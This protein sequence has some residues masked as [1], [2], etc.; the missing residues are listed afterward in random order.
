[1]LN[2]FILKI[3]FKIAFVLLFAFYDQLI[4][5]TVENSV[6]IV[7]CH[8]FQ[9]DQNQC[10]TDIT[11]TISLQSD[12]YSSV[13]AIYASCKS[14]ND[15]I[16]IFYN[17][18]NTYLGLEYIT[19]DLKFKETYDFLV[20]SLDF[21]KLGIWLTET[22]YLQVNNKL[23]YIYN[24][25]D[26]GNPDKYCSNQSIDGNS[27]KYSFSTLIVPTTISD[28]S[29]SI[30]SSSN[31]PEGKWSISNLLFSLFKCKKE[32]FYNKTTNNCDACPQFCEICLNSN[33]CSKC[34]DTY[35]LFNQT[36]CS[37]SC[38]TQYFR[39]QGQC[40]Q[41][42][43]KCSSCISST[44][45]QSCSDNTFLKHCQDISIENCTCN[46]LSQV[47]KCLQNNP[48]CQTFKDQNNED[49]DSL[50]T[51]QQ[52][53]QSYF[54]QDQ[55]CVPKCKQTYYQFNDT[56]CLP[57]C[58][59]NYFSDQ[60][61]NCQSCDNSCQTCAT[62]ADLCQSC[63][64]QYFPVYLQTNQM[65][66]VNQTSSDIDIYNKCNAKNYK[67]LFKDLQNKYYCQN[68]CPYFVDSTI[69]CKACDDPNCSD[70]QSNYQTCQTCKIGY[71][72]IADTKKC[73]ITCTEDQNKDCFCSDGYYINNDKCLKCTDK[74]SS[75]SQDGCIKCNSGQ[76][77]DISQKICQPCPLN[78]ISCID[79]VQCQVCS[80]SYYINDQKKC[81]LQ[82]NC[83]GYIQDKMCKQCNDSCQKCTSDT[84]C[85]SCKDGFYFYKGVN[86]QTCQKSCPNY[87][88][89]INKQ[90]VDSCNQGYIDQK[91]CKICADPNCY[92]CQV[93]D[94]QQ[95][96]QKCVAKFYLNK[97]NNECVL[98]CPEKTFADKA[99]KTC[100]PCS[101]SC[102]TCI[103]Q[104]DCQTC[105]Q[106]TFLINLN[107][108]ILCST[109]NSGLYYYQQ[110]CVST[111]PIGIGGFNNQNQRI[112]VSCQ[113]TNC[114]QCSTITPNNSNQQG[115]NS[116]QC[117][118]C[119]SGSYLLSGI[120]VINCPNSMYND[121]TYNICQFCSSQCQTCSSQSKCTSCLNGQFLYQDT[122]LQSCPDSFY[123]DNNKCIACP[124]IGCLTCDKDKCYTCKPY[125]AYI[126]SESSCV[127]CPSQ[128]YVLDKNC[129]QC[130]KSS[131]LHVDKQVCVTSDECNDE[132]YIEGN[133]CKKCL[134]Q[135]QCETETSQSQIS[136]CRSQ[137]QKLC[138][139][140]VDGQYLSER[141]FCNPCPQ[142]CKLCT[143][144]SCT[145]CN[146]RYCLVN[147]K[148]Y[149]ISQS[150]G[151][152]TVTK[153]DDFNKNCINSGPNYGVCLKCIKGP[154]LCSMCDQNSYLYNSQCVF[155]CPSELVADKNIYLE[156]FIY[157]GICRN[158]CLDGYIKGP[159]EK[160][161]YCPDYCSDCSPL[162]KDLAKQVGQ[163][164]NC[165][166][167][168]ND[169][170]NN[171]Y[172][173]FLLNDTQVQSCVQ[174]C[175][176]GYYIKDQSKCIQCGS[177]CQRCDDEKTCK[178]CQLGYFLDTD[179]NCRES[180][181]NGYFQDISQNKC[182]SCQVTQC[183]K[184]SQIGYCL[185]CDDKYLL[186]GKCLDCGN[187][188]YAEQKSKTCQRCLFNCQQCSDAKSCTKCQQG[189]YYQQYLQ[190][191]SF[192]CQKNCLQGYY[193]EDSDQTCRACDISNCFQCSK[194]N[195]CDQCQEAYFLN[196]VLD[197]NN[198]QL[199]SCVGQCNSGYYENSQTKKCTQCQPNCQNC[200]N[201]ICNLCVN[202]F[203]LTSDTQ[204]C[205]NP[206]PQGYLQVANQCVKCADNCKNCSVLNQCSI[207][208]DGFYLKGQTCSSCIQYCDQCQD[209][210]SCKQCKNSY[211]YNQDT[212]SCGSDCPTGYFKSLNI[213]KKCVSNCLICNDENKCQTC[214]NQFYLT[215]DTQ[216]CLG[217]CP[218]GYSQVQNQ[219]I[220]C[221]QNCQNCSV[222]DQ[223][224]KCQDGFYL[225]DQQCVDSCPQG[226]SQVDTQCVKCADNC[227]NCSVLNQC[228]ICQDGFYLKGQ[229]CSQCI[230]YCDQC[231]DE[232]TCKQCS[233]SYYYNQDTK[234]C[235]SDCPTG[236]F[237]SQNICKKCVSNCLICNDENKCQ[238]CNDQFYL[239]S[240]TQQ[241][242]GQC[243]QGYSQVQNQCI[244]CAQNCQNCSDPNQCSNCQI[245]YYLSNK[246]CSPCNANCMSCIDENKCQ[247][248]KLNYLYISDL[249]SCQDNC[250][251]GYSP[252]GNSCIKCAD[253]CLKCT[254][255]NECTQCQSSFYLDSQECSP[256]ISN[257]SECQDINNCEKCQPNYL[258][259]KDKNT[260]EYPCPSGYFNQIGTDECSQ[261]I[262]NCKTCQTQNK[263]QFCI[264]GFFLKLDS[265][266]CVD[267]CP[268]GYSLKDFQCIKC[269]SNCI[270]CDTNHDCK[271]CKQGFYLNDN[272]ICQECS[273][274]N[275]IS[276]QTNN[277]SC[278]I[279]KSNYVFDLQ[280]NQ[281][282]QKCPENSFVQ[283]DS[284]QRYFCQQC[285]QNCQQCSNSTECQQCKPSFY[286]DKSNNNT[287]SQ[288]IENC[289]NCNSNS[290]SCDQ[291]Q[292]NYYFIPKL[293]KCIQQCPLQ[294]FDSIDTSERLVCQ[295]CINNCDSCKNSSQCEKCSE[296]FYLRLDTYQCV[297]KCPY[298]YSLKGTSC[299]K[300]ISNCQ[301]CSDM[302]S[303]EQCR[304]G[305]YLNS[306][307][308]CVSCQ[309]NNCDVCQDTSN[310]CQVCSL[311]FILS[312]NQS[313]CI[314][315]CPDGQF[316]QQSNGNLICSKCSQNCSLCIDNTQCNKC[317]QGFTL[318]N[319]QCVQCNVQQCSQCEN[320]VQLCDQCSQSLY[321]NSNQLKCVSQ[322]QADEYLDS[323]LKMCKKC[324]QNCKKCQSDS[325][326]L[327]C[328][329]PYLLNDTNKCI[330]C[331]PS[332]YFDFQSKICTF[333]D[334]SNG[335][336]IDN[337]V[338]KKCNYTCQ[339]CSGI[340]IS[341]C[342]TCPTNRKLYMN[343]C[344]C[345]EGFIENF[346]QTCE[347]QQIDSNGLQGMQ[348][349]MT[350]LSTVSMLGGAGTISSLRGMEVSQMVSFLTY[351]NVNYQ[352]NSNQYLKILYSDNLSP[353]F[354]NALESLFQNKQ[355]QNST[356][357]T[358]NQMTIRVLS[359]EVYVDPYLQT[360][361]KF[362]VNQKTNNFLFN[363]SP[364]IILHLLVAFLLLMKFLVYKY[365][366]LQYS[367]KKTVVWIK[368]NFR[369]TVFLL[370]FYLTYQE[371]L[372]IVLLQLTKPFNEEAVSIVGSILTL[373][374]SFYMIYL[375]YFI[376][377]VVL[378]M[379][380][381][382]VKEKNQKYGCIFYGLKDNRTA[383]IFILIKFVQ[384]TMICMGTIYAYHS[385]QILPQIVISGIVFLYELMIRPFYYKLVAFAS[386]LLNSLYLALLFLSYM[387]KSQ[388]QNTNQITSTNYSDS[389]E[390]ILLAFIIVKN[391]IVLVDIIILIYGFFKI[392]C[393]KRSLSAPTEEGLSNRTSTDLESS[394]S[395][396]IT[397]RNNPL[398]MNNFNSV[399]VGKQTTSEVQNEFR[400][401]DQTHFSDSP[402][403]R[404]DS[405]SPILKKI[406][407]N[408]QRSSPPGQLD[409]TQILQNQILGKEIL[410]VK[411]KQ[412]KLFKDDINDAL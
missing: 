372:L 292:L 397:W 354:P 383:Q 238:T 286:V 81:V 106:N 388:Q 227:K 316:S 111:C 255:T 229:T 79:S 337:N 290:N 327:E 105:P 139:T 263:C 259:I 304:Q 49:C 92:S 333:C 225:K 107:N 89:L 244:K 84:V 284:N 93:V 365:T 387:I 69:Y 411:W 195:Q 381:L 287:C 295:Q 6:N 116:Q 51:C 265:Q 398:M 283:K 407:S 45:C 97:K 143:A 217:Q 342:L 346:S 114:Q 145:S 30:G 34:I 330:Q 12:N 297:N 340:S 200:P 364:L 405:S 91:T 134:Y 236:Y 42:L 243:P 2:H 334:E 35:N 87:T 341:Q 110:S 203:Y 302:N 373:L 135:Q 315:Q 61:K 291:C 77:L 90:C 410:V 386:F 7:E 350:A 392:I 15:I 166:K 80:D 168:N 33:S 151:E 363:I 20:V 262:D 396:S 104:K 8:P 401:T 393:G 18:K 384:K 221:A 86:N 270:E 256:C 154:L 184:C 335:N 353:I 147:N 146:D 310:Q 94:N 32:F 223:C 362:M 112:C 155:N 356:N 323:T 303:C 247:S 266:D 339:T 299:I 406:Q 338:C 379:P 47:G 70:C 202:N 60:N 122:C 119:N 176:T 99:N 178:Q 309:V 312:L 211:Y 264:D 196:S 237:K 360:E 391:V 242:L 245:G 204:K 412:N 152:N 378:F 402:L 249:E 277:Q 246:T 357:Q 130:L 285:I 189:T 43:Q 21:I 5:Q 181:Q 44:S 9:P 394:L 96:C 347:K 185:Q 161:F 219:C 144:D 318:I 275:C 37:E 213:C 65:I 31:R 377:K 138:Q 126:S 54:L 324:H 374:A 173:L 278:D 190:D 67:Y 404:K 293:N 82:T 174:N 58:P 239:A 208:Q 133:L 159:D 376:F 380:Y 180:C 214:N 170:K 72:L 268:E 317:Q 16:Q 232:N 328:K 71:S 74:C 361:F 127:S 320:S 102:Q 53:I 132:Y 175:P 164:Y 25:S 52:C 188:Y 38:P 230:Q 1:M 279:C 241:C 228:S 257:C 121:T 336:F 282:L 369:Q 78:C 250:P 125:Y 187:Y 98:K 46:Q 177:F 409:S 191:R 205:V 14:E 212:K 137:N 235:G 157:S 321:L 375:L 269:L 280:S 142:G 234:S 231:E 66:C 75:C 141:G 331:D 131:Y 101:S 24:N 158:S 251:Q 103:N 186:D 27:T 73:L 150:G 162:D 197:Q 261:C 108:Q 319:K 149:L 366:K 123:S 326:C 294:Y 56:Q 273:V 11:S 128:Q 183:A 179:N 194:R 301:T 240:D 4:A 352:G 258:L 55:T 271:K 57:Q 124:Q 385:D 209:E 390:L 400:R 332:H 305:Y 59:S 64:Q 113:D 358:T 68:E 370:I 345:Q 28:I 100:S 13:P 359:Q 296:S 314:K 216:Q 167:C 48:F 367:K 40:F 322:C 220:K 19:F 117:L 36:S 109:C 313:S 289:I 206:C 276:C 26:V 272:Q 201:G 368:N 274:P 140:C 85:Q 403:T 76:Y 23:I 307:K 252:V 160:C 115:I 129:K 210:S 192:S 62:Q 3:N 389:F 308:Q 281:C 222:L 351:V 29:I 311:G 306:D 182:I 224:S 172:Y 226:Y 267:S 382:T 253:N 408:F 118:K 156:K 198:Q 39:Y 343:R 254:S 50:C 399:E 199:Y 298:G 169:I 215:S 10:Q 22:S 355:N 288:C 260:C 349:G 329:S 95:I 83:Q 300:C 371:L 193:P 120:C 344:I 17:N 218:Q 171:P 63:S 148:C 207:C 248:C 348:S 165:T 136:N 88:D 153:C 41:C 233:N 325:M 163:N 395:K